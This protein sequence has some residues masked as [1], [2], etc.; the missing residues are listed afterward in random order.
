[1]NIE[2]SM[3][4]KVREELLHSLCEWGVS[5]GTRDGH[6]EFRSIAI[7][8]ALVNLHVKKKPFNYKILRTEKFPTD[9]NE[10]Y[11]HILRQE[12]VPDDKIYAHTNTL[13]MEG[14]LNP[15]WRRYEIR[16]TV[17]MDDL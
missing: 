17:K 4:H 15:F 6:G 2:V 9:M 13:E 8:E 7:E 16:P 1:V 5:R 3:E 12:N 10:A 11:E 14:F